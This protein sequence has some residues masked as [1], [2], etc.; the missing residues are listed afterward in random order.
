MKTAG[1]LHANHLATKISE[2]LRDSQMQMLAL[3]QTSNSYQDGAE[4]NENYEN[5][6]NN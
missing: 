6:F 1:Y 3:A 2:E 5:S 4:I